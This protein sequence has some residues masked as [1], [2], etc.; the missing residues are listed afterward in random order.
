MALPPVPNRHQDSG[1]HRQRIA[2]TVNGIT[3]F[4]FDDSRVRTPSEISAGLVPF[5]PAFVPGDSRRLVTDTTGATF[6]TT[7]L[8]ALFD[9]AGKAADAATAA[10]GV[11]TTVV[12]TI[13]P[14]IY[15]VTRLYLRYSNV[16]IN[17]MPGAIIQQDRGGTGAD[18]IVDSNTTGVAP[19]YACIHINPLTYLANPA[20]PVTAIENV[21]IFG[22]GSVLGPFTVTGAYNNVTLGIASN[23]CDACVIDGIYVFGFHAENILLNPSAWNT[24]RGLKIINCEVEGGGEVGINNARDFEVVSNDVHDSWMQNGLGGNGDGGQV[25]F[26]RVRSMAGNGISIG[27]SGARDV[28][29][30]RNTVIGFNE[31]INTNVSSGGGFAIALVDDGATTT[32]KLGIKVIGNVINLNQSGTG[33]VIGADYAMAS[34]YVDIEHNT[35]IAGNSG[36]SSAGIAIID[37]SA[38]YNMRDNSFAVGVGNMTVCHDILGGTPVV[39]IWSF[40]NK[41]VSIDI[42]HISLFSVVDSQRILSGNLTLTGCTTAPTTTYRVVKRGK[43]YVMQIDGVTAV[44]NATTCTLTG[45]P[46]E[47]FPARNLN[48][49]FPVVDNGVNLDGL[50][51]IT[52]AGAVNLFKDINASAFTNVGTKGL[53]GPYSLSVQMT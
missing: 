52:A 50:L 13:Y 51:Q 4:Q 34:S 53:P 10:T 18:A 35:I 11:G 23:D 17:L 8:Q 19:A 48:F 15:K 46:A 22:G 30:C 2:E 20:A 25:C 21:K 33:S 6:V 39:N 44:S 12:V 31:I 36:V 32:P 28:N 9:A 14:G 26:N 24:C 1:A 49:R 40:D 29:A 41:D 5:N 37:G 16:W 47:L 45:L 3:S 42:Q 27:G 38:R 43:S 7:Q